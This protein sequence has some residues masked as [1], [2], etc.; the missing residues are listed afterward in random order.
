MDLGNLAITREPLDEMSDYFGVTSQSK[1][2]ILI[3]DQWIFYVDLLGAKPRL[4]FQAEITSTNEKH[5]FVRIGEM[6]A[7]SGIE[8]TDDLICLD[9]SSNVLVYFDFDATKCELKLFSSNLLEAHAYSY[10]L[11][12]NMLFV[13]RHVH[14]TEQMN[15]LTVYDLNR[16]KEKGSF[17]HDSVKLHEMEVFD[18]HGCLEIADELDYFVLSQK[19]RSLLVYSMVGSFKLIA[20]VPILARSIDRIMLSK[21]RSILVELGTHRLIHFKLLIGQDNEFKFK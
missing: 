15:S 7:I 16:V 1:Y 20:C 13:M 12:R 10:K 19:P 4:I 3:K 6:H 11:K 17:L 18:R 9:K 5:K 14:S 21:H 8:R 2:L